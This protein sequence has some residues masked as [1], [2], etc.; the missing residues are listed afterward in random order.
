MQLFVR[1]RMVLMFNFRFVTVRVYYIDLDFF[2]YFKLNLFPFK[3]GSFFISNWIFF[4]WKFQSFQMEEKN[5]FILN[6]EHCKNS[7]ETRRNYHWNNVI[8]LW[9]MPIASKSKQLIYCNWIEKICGNKKNNNTQRIKQ[10]CCYYNN[11]FC[12]VLCCVCNIPTHSWKYWDKP[13][14]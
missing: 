10:K 3:I 4:N 11:G 12:T 14:D 6:I 5:K 8:H 7:I 2:F 13:S 9:K 1:Y